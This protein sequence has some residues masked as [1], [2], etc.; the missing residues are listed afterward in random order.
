MIVKKNKL[1][2][3]FNTAIIVMFFV[4]ITLLWTIDMGTIA[5]LI[6]WILFFVIIV[7]RDCIAPK[8]KR[9]DDDGNY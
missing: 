6:Y 9:S 3:L 2:K 5:P 1:R 8:Q 7:L 4:Y